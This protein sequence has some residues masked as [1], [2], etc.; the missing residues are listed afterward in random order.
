MQREYKAN[1]K[2]YLSET[3]EKTI[4]ELQ[5]LYKQ[6]YEVFG[7]N[8]LRMNKPFGYEVFAQRFGGIDL[9]L[10]YAQKRLLEYCEGKTDRIE[11]LEEKIVTGLN[12]TWRY[13][14]NYMNTI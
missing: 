3:A 13:A 8:W 7:E 10:S 2:K 1:N 9:R 5:K 6:F 11:E 12:K 14:N 4:P